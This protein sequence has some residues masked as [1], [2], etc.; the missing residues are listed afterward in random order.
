VTVEDRAVC[1]A[2]RGEEFGIAHE[3]L[4]RLA[5]GEQINGK[6]LTPDDAVAAEG[7]YRQQDE[8]RPAGNAP[9]LLPHADRS[10]GRSGAK[11]IRWL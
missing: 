9:E 11:I 4:E 3:E 10:R 6:R 7:E 2:D 5:V 1:D 8:R